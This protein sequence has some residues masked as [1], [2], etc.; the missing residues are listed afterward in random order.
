M[1]ENIYFPKNIEEV[2][3]IVCTHSNEKKKFIVQ[4]AK[5]GLSQWREEVEGYV[6]NLTH[7]NNIIKMYEL[8]GTHYLE[9]EAGVILADISKFLYS[10]NYFW[11]PNPTETTAT[12][13][14][15]IA[16]NARGLFEGYY[17]EISKHVE[18][19]E[20]INNIIVSATLKLLKKPEA[21]WGLVFLI[22]SKNNL[23]NFIEELKNIDELV[24]IE[25]IDKNTI[26]Y[27]RELK[28]IAT[29]LNSLPDISDKYSGLVY[30]EMHNSEEQI[31]EIACSLI[32][33]ADKYG[34]SDDDNWA[35][36]GEEEID[37]LRLL[38]HA[39]PESISTFLTKQMLYTD[40]E[41]KNKSF[42]ELINS[43]EN[44]AKNKNIEVA[45]YGH[46]KIN[47]LH[48]TFIPKN[49]SEQEIASKLLEKWNKELKQGII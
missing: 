24:A 44:E 38:R 3:K 14:G 7:M 26:K 18:R 30:I 11:V 28:K 43:Y 35:L 31:E 19:V 49:D 47:C 34:C 2:K 40:F 42:T 32:E 15:I 16:C 13:G 37:K 9:V 45:I 41:V 17:G 25:Y 5:T 27:I 48:A 46:A 33:L 10:K 12:I 8:D 22:E 20:K 21:I 23:L 1:S 6:I 36:S 4:G 29:K 39:A